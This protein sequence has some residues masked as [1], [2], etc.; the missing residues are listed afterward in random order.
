[1]MTSQYFTTVLSKMDFKTKS[2][3]T[4]KI[5]I[6]D[7]KRQFLNQNAYID[8]TVKKQLIQELKQ[9]KKLFTQKLNKGQQRRTVKKLTKVM[10]IYFKSHIWELNPTK[11]NKCS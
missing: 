10:C 3:I 7:K 2:K 6:L 8:E 9:K 4:S 11:K 1:M 5:S